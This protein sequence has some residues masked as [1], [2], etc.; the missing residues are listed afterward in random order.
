[1]RLALSVRQDLASPIHVGL[2]LLTTTVTASSSFAGSSFT[3]STTV[4]RK[5]NTMSG[6][7][8]ITRF[9]GPYATGELLGDGFLITDGLLINNGLLYSGAGQLVSGASVWTSSGFVA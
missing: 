7:G 5:F 9:Q 2:P 6:S 3:W 1:M 4:L 8:L